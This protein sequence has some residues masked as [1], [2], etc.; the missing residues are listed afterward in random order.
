[1]WIAGGG[2]KVTLKIAAKYAQYTNFDGTPEGFGR[3]SEILKKH[4]AT[5]GTDFDAIVR[6]ANYN[7]AIGSTEAEVA[8]RLRVVK[9]RLTPLVGEAAAEAALD[10]FRGMPAVGT[11]EQIIEN[12]SALKAQGL[13]YGIFY[14]PEAAYDTSGI[15]LFEREVLPA[16]R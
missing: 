15:E 12:L 6:S 9:D 14:F 5:V 4:C 8:E 3:K 7:V 10:A 16:L 13:D 1:L 11:P 2:E